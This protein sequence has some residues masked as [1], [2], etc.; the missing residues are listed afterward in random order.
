MIKT[1]FEDEGLAI[2]DKPAGISM[3]P[4]TPTRLPA[5][6]GLR[7]TNPATVVDLIIKQFPEIKKED[8]KY[9]ERTGIV[10]RLDQDTSGLVIVAKNPKT[11]K[12][13]QEQFKKRK[14]QK[15]YLALVFGKT[16]QKGFVDIP[17]TRDRDKSKMKIAYLQNEKSK[18]AITNY[19]LIKYYPDKNVSLLEVN[20]KTGRMHQIRVHLKFL[21]H[22][23][24][25]DQV[26][27]NKASRRLSK[28]LNI[29]R[30]FLH[31]SEITFSNP[32]TN[33]KQV[34]KSELPNELKKLVIT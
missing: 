19:K 26:Y 23:I 16:D 7:R 24:I 11:L 33:K 18:P 30:Q 27:F 15:K 5:R 13:L 3:H 34:F 12:K 6:Q 25:G 29:I 31:A 17:L 1:I 22:P 2:L 10:H 32:E 14:V 9:P 8:W 28:E 20:P 4:P 21:G